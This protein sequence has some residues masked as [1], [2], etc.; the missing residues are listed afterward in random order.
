MILKRY[1]PYLYGK[2]YT[3]K[4]YFMEENIALRE[5]VMERYVEYVKSFTQLELKQ[6]F[7]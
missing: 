1:F 2:N 6:L 7:V 3:Y 4:L 5:A